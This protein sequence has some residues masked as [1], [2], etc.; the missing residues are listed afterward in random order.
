MT[1]MSESINKRVVICRKL[2]NLTQSQA[3]ERL[4]MKSSTYSQMERKGKISADCLLKLSEIF[5]A[6]PDYLLYGKKKN[7][8][9]DFSP[10]APVVNQLKQESV[11]DN[12]YGETIIITKSE[13]NLI[14][15]LRNLSK[16]SKAQVIDYINRVY[17]DSKN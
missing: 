17:K 11:F 1:N 15:L 14:K 2:A 4:G 6:D 12:N 7:Q 8:E 9:F 16:D 13:E 5:G 3:A 10:P